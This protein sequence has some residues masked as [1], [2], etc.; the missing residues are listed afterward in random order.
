MG[1][2]VSVYLPRVALFGMIGG[3][4]VV[5]PQAAPLALAVAAFIV[6]DRWFNK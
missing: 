5:A 3:A 2:L 1:R 6:Y 4:A